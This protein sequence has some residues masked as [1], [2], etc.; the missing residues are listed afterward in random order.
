MLKSLLGKEGLIVAIITAS[1]YASVY[2]FER[3]SAAALNIPLDLISINISTI[4][5]DSFLFYIFFFPIAI[6]SSSLIIWRNKTKTSLRTSLTHLGICG[7]Y[8]TATWLQMDSTKDSFFIMLFCTCLLFWLLSEFMPIKDVDNSESTNDLAK[9]A[10]RNIMNVTG[11]L[12]VLSLTFIS[13][14]RSNVLK[15]SNDEFKTFTLNDKEYAIVKIYDE[16]LFAWHV[17]SG[18]LKKD[19]IYF[20]MENISGAEFKKKTFTPSKKIESKNE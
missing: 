17:D 15:D 5:N 12:F 1:I 6:I 14:G 8:A 9:T 7:T 18:K 2:F 10:G 4:S 11:C 20:R 19:L 16:N 13:L 3:G